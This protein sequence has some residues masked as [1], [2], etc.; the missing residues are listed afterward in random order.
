MAEDLWVSRFWEVLGIAA[1]FI[2]YGRFYLQW[3]VSEIQKRSVIPVAFWYMSSLGSLMLL[4]YAVY[5][6][7]PIGALSHCFNIVIYVRNLIHIWREKGV[8]TS[9]LSAGVH[10][11][12]GLIVLGALGLAVHTWL[13]EYDVV[14][15]VS[16]EAARQTWFWL[17]VGV[18]GQ[19]LFGCRFALQWAATEFHHKSVVPVAFWYFSVIAAVLLTASHLQR[20]EWVFVLGMGATVLVYLRNLWLI[21]AHPPG[22]APAE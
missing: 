14:R 5:L 21:Y 18:V 2:F 7:S 6:Q 10:T 8:L 22:A 12:A 9:R 20:R 11:A 3:F 15:E 1:A 13:R 17:G 19:G 16:P 4:A